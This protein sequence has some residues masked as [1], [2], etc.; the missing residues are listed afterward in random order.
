[1]DDLLSAQ[2]FT[3]RV[4]NLRGIKMR[5]IF[6]GVVA[7][8][9][10]NASS[11]EMNTLGC[12]DC[13]NFVAPS[14]SGAESIT[15]PQIG[16][17]VYDTSVNKFRGYSSFGTWQS[18][19]KDDN[20]VT[21]TSSYAAA[22]TD[23]LILGNGNLTITLPLAA[24][25]PGKVF[26]IRNVSSGGVTTVSASG[27]DL[28]DGYSSLPLAQKFDDVEVTSDGTSSWHVVASRIASTTTVLTTS[29]GSAGHGTYSTPAGVRYLKIRMVGGGGGGG[30]GG[31]SG[32]AG[33]TG[34]STTF[35]TSLLAANGGGGGG[36]SSSGAGSG[37]TA[38]ITGTAAV[39]IAITGTGGGFGP[40][41]ST[42]ASYISGGSGGTSPFGGT[43]VSDPNVTGGSAAA[44]S[45][46]GGSGGGT[47]A[48]ASYAGFGGASGGYID[49]TINA[50][51]TSYSYVVG[52]GGTAGVAGSNGYAGGAGGSGVIV[53]GEYY[54]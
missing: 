39:G 20:V 12:T 1:L 37:G 26:K 44:N 13:W 21:K 19:S 45:G 2:F 16:L 31:S 52:A 49:V 40:S 41:G 42:T 43:G 15:T 38:S 10:L 51:S 4:L 22:A 33:G 28:I 47:G 11:L 9:S 25:Y 53:I 46:S 18:M 3:R 32:G 14:I 27:S 5:S 48:T 29:S 24:S 8:L 30:G 17:V 34:V 36:N 50:P 23:N 6:F 7:F 54:Q 35:G